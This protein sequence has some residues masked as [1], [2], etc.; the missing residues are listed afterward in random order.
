M[1]AEQ[2]MDRI[3]TSVVCEYEQAWGVEVGKWVLAA[4][5]TCRTILIPSRPGRC[6][7]HSRINRDMTQCGMSGSSLLGKDPQA[8][9]G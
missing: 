2:A 4:T 7:G 8:R 3:S 5:G 1:T 9:V 6:R